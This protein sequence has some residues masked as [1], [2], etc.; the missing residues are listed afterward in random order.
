LV[1]PAGPVNFLKT[2]GKCQIVFS[3]AN[4]QPIPIGQFTGAFSSPKQVR[5]L[6]QQVSEQVLKDLGIT[7]KPGMLDTNVLKESYQQNGVIKF[8]W[9]TMVDRPDIFYSLMMSEKKVQDAIAK[10]IHPIRVYG[11]KTWKDFYNLQALRRS[12]PITGPNAFKLSKGLWEAAMSTGAKNSNPAM[13]KVASFIR[14]IGRLPGFGWTS[15][16]DFG[17]VGKAEYR[18]AENILPNTRSRLYDTKITE[19]GLKNIL[20]SYS[21]LVELGLLPKISDPK[22]RELWEILPTHYSTSFLGLGKGRQPKKYIG[23]DGKTYYDVV[24]SYP[25]AKVIEKAHEHIW[26]WGNREMEKIDR[27]QPGARDPIEVASL[28]S[29]AMIYIHGGYEG[30]GRTTKFFKNLILH[31]YG[32]PFDLRFNEE[33]WHDLDLSLAEFVNKVRLG[34]FYAT[35]RTGNI[36]PDRVPSPDAAKIGL[37]TGNHDFKRFNPETGKSENLFSNKERK[38]IAEK[39]L[40]DNV[41]Q[42]FKFGST[43]RKK[44]IYK[45]H[46]WQDQAGVPYT[47]DPKSNKLYPISDWAN[48]LYGQG[49]ELFLKHTGQNLYIFRDRNP[50]FQALWNNNA[51]LFKDMVANKDKGHQIEVVKYDVLEQHNR[52]DGGFGRLYLHDFERGLV[53]DFLGQFTPERRLDPEKYPLAVL[54]PSRGNQISAK[55]SGPTAL[56]KW[57]NQG[58]PENIHFGE[59]IAAYSTRRAFLFKMENDLRKNH[60]ELLEANKELFL[61]ARK[62]AYTAAR[63]LLEKQGYIQF[64][65]E[66]YKSKPGQAEHPFLKDNPEIH[67]RAQETEVPEFLYKHLTHQEWFYKTYEQGVTKVNQK[68]AYVIRNIAIGNLKLLGLITEVQQAEVLSF[69]KDLSR[70]VDAEIKRSNKAGEKLDPKQVEGFISRSVAKWVSEYDSEGNQKVDGGALKSLFQGNRK[71][72]IKFRE[73]LDKLANGVFVDYYQTRGLDPEFNR[74]FFDFYLHTV[75]EHPQ[76]YKSTSVN[77]FYEI[78]LNPRGELKFAKWGVSILYKG[79]LGEEIVDAR[80][81]PYVDQAELIDKAKLGGLWWFSPARWKFEFRR[82]IKTA[83]EDELRLIPKEDEISSIKEN[84]KLTLQER[85]AEIAKVKE[86]QKVGELLDNYLREGLKIDLDQIGIVPENTPVIN[87]RGEKVELEKSIKET[88]KELRQLE[89]EKAKKKSRRTSMWIKDSSSLLLVS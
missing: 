16:H 87:S 82:K 45:G 89:Q 76:L 80:F 30:N 15:L 68:Y 41:N 75:G 22:E 25:S 21:E 66:L 4:K 59:I 11:E 24:M 70:K 34:V 64:V 28:V 69:L 73:G 9:A 51:K 37:E 19:Q 47:Y 52:A 2:G 33:L 40:P 20:S 44:L 8:E 84:Q 32:L 81:S 86:T 17:F 72:R 6:E 38:L 36:K 46:F 1:L 39:S 67:K 85:E 79:K 77:P 60:P 18:D 53:R 61:Q 13:Q 88:L 29:Y 78:L 10:G 50:S 26:N 83:T 54:A 56:Q 43:F 63:T 42:V 35:Q 74:S 48:S 23:E 71:S 7:M 31:K 58:R 57:F 5:E 12:T 62:D 14:F 49:G 65:T 3:T 27:G 55:R